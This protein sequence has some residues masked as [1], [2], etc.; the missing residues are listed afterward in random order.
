VPIR[1]AM[2]CCMWHPLPLFLLSRRTAVVIT[3]AM[4]FKQEYRILSSVTT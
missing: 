3:A 1:S 2:I 4:G